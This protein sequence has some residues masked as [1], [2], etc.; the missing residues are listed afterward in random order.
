M[1]WRSNDRVNNRLREIRKELAQ[2]DGVPKNAVFTNE[3]L[4]ATVQRKVKKDAYH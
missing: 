2:Q 3:Q 1:G 4:A